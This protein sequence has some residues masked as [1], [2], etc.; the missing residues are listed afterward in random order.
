MG[1]DASATSRRKSRPKVQKMRHLTAMMSV[2]VLAVTSLGQQLTDRTTNQDV[3][4]MVSLGLSDDVVIDKIHA[5]EAT[6]FDTSVPGLKTLKLDKVSDTV[7]RVMINPDGNTARSGSP[8]AAPATVGGTG[9]PEEAAIYNV[10][11]GK[12]T[13]M[14]PEVVN[15]QTGGVAKS[16]ATLLLLKGDTNG[17]GNEAYESNAGESSLLRFSSKPSRE[18]PQPS[19]SFC[20]C[21]RR[22]IGVSSAR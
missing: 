9:V 5:T 4:D 8:A 11:D 21:T 2:L 12:P 14:E 17:E 18:R 1:S 20:D 15:W 3:I 13:E 16:H 19:T 6:D 7:I 10:L 22:I